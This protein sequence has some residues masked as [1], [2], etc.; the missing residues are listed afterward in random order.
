MIYLSTDHWQHSGLKLQWF[1]C[2]NYCEEEVN[3][4]SA[5]T[6]ITVLGQSSSQSA[7]SHLL[8][9]P[10]S[11]CSHGKASQSTTLPRG[12]CGCSHT[13][14]THQTHTAAV[15]ANTLQ[16]A[17]QKRRRA[18][19]DIASC[20]IFQFPCCR[21]SH[22]SLLQGTIVIPEWFPSELRGA[23]VTWLQHI[24]DYYLPHD[25]AI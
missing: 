1:L 25:S 23:D 6:N 7:H 10:G 15:A 21:Y 14:D 11:G 19:K 13:S 12:K 20:G 3:I 5:E 2:P 24:T 18:W 22:H 4:H 9:R 16:L 17:L 8:K